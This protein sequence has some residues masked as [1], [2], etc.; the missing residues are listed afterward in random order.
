MHINIAYVAG[1]CA[2]PIAGVLAVLKGDKPERFGALLFICPTLIGDALQFIS[3]QL[4][5]S[6]AGALPYIDL[7]TTF[8]TCVGFLY[9]AV[10]YASQWLAA[11]MVVQ[12]A[13]LYFARSYIDSDPPNLHVYALEVNL[14]TATVGMIL[15]SATITSWLGR[16]RKR[17]EEEER[18]QRITRREQELQARY[19][20]HFQPLDASSA[21][22]ANAG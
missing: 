11:A 15:I 14:I 22:V 1:V 21:P 20:P 16:I 10:R 6:L 2:V 19:F 13:E 12:G 4:G 3:G 17:R 5:Y 7:A 8:A 18:Q 9:L